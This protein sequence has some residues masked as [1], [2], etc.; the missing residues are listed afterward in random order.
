MGEC[1]C[2]AAWLWLE[3][4]PS[5]SLAIGPRHYWSDILQNFSR[6]IVRFVL[7]RLYLEI[8][9]TKVVLQRLYCEICIAKVVSQDTYRESY[10]TRYAS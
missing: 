7:Q 1:R 3:H 5:I 4:A 10:I 9:I 8:H 2:A 6:G